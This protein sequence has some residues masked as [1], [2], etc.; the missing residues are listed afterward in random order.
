MKETVLII[1]ATGFSIFVA[2]Q[3]RA[4]YDITTF[5]RSPANLLE[6]EE[7]SSFTKLSVSLSNFNVEYHP[8][9][10]PIMTR[11]S[12]ERVKVLIIEKNFYLY[13]SNLYLS[14]PSWTVV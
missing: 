7:V 1:R 4:L 11:L 10:Q 6:I 3:T 12:L 2:P 13:L 9:Y 5:F 8:L 14:F